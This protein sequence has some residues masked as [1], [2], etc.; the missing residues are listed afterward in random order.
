[1]DR[2]YKW[3]RDLEIS[4][5]LDIGA[6]KGEFADFI[7]S[8]LSSSAIYSFEPNPDCFDQLVLNRSRDLSFRAF[9]FAL[10]A[11]NG[12]A[13]L[14][15]SAWSPSS[16]MLQMSEW[17]KRA[18]PHKSEHTSTTVAV[19]RLDDFAKE[20]DLRDPIL[21][22]IDVQGAED[23]VLRGGE[24]TVRRANI[25]L[26]EPSFSE[27]YKGQVRFNEIADYAQR[28]GFEYMGSLSPAG[29]DPRDGR[30]LYE[31]SIFVKGSLSSPP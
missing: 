4:T 13:L 6:H 22:K 24:N 30:N 19:R 23:H 17:H 2:R 31:D 12:K 14:H 7:R 5:V 9:N 10:G 18:F 27:L 29:T 20:I 8:V 15:E 25:L 26:M 16:S 1:V 11:H 28:L 21:I 3:L